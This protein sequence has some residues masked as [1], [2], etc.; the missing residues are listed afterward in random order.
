MSSKNIKQRIGEIAV[1][2]VV[3]AI[4]L[5]ILI[6]T[7]SK[8]MENGSENKCRKRLEL[9]T[10]A[11]NTAVKDQENSEKWVMMFDQKNSRRL[12]D[13]LK[14][15]MKPEAANRIDTSEYYIKSENGRLYVR[16]VKHPKI[17]DYFVK[18]PEGISVP[19]SKAERSEFIDHLQITGV[20]TYMQN[21]SINPDKPE[22]MKF[23]DQDD[24]KKIF[25]DMKVTILYVGGGEKQLSPNDYQLSTEGFDMSTPG[26]KKIKIA[27]K[28]DKMWNH[29]IY[30]DFTFEVLKKAQC[31]PLEVRFGNETYELAAWDWTDYVAEA[32][33][34]EGGTKDF[35]ASIVY[36][37]GS[38]YYYPDGFNIDSRRDNSDPETAAA[39][40]DD[41]TF[42]AYRIEFKT[43]II[44]AAKEDE[45]EM[46]KATDG[47]L[48]LEDE[49][50]YIWQSEPS[51]ELDS[52]WIRVFCELKKKE[53]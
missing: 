40:I 39:D 16:C 21:E 43:D 38:Y 6:P 44:V 33:R 4:L 1:C 25:A 52:G 18:I 34:S 48:L 2:T 47:A 13:T 7:I 12:L 27:Y 9:I 24:L 41:S 10:S 26:T 37:G 45:K 20:R 29:M 50:V 30:A 53:S 42:A 51:K 23:T 15:T 32:S 17:D 3:L 19:D 46:K 35:D 49:Q 14:L 28:T 8:C 36:F 22:Q 11:L 5:T 31:P